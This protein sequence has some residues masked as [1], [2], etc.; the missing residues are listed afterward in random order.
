MAVGYLTK[1]SPRFMGSQQG[2]RRR[3]AALQYSQGAR[4]SPDLDPLHHA[5]N[6]SAAIQRFFSS[7]LSSA[8]AQVYRQ[9]RRR[10][11]NQTPQRRTT[12]RTRSEPAGR[13]ARKTLNDAQAF[14]RRTVPLAYQEPRLFPHGREAPPAEMAN[15]ST[16][17]DYGLYEHQAPVLNERLMGKSLAGASRPIHGSQH[18]ALPRKTRDRCVVPFNIRL[19]AQLSLECGT[20]CGGGRIS[21]CVRQS[22]GFRIS[23]LTESSGINYDRL[24]K[25]TCAVALIL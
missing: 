24:T 8:L 17:S 9:Q 14:Q 11:I 20:E 23:M 22:T 13:T 25:L 2:R 12:G 21:F 3:R 1:A 10:V 6:Y 15:R 16:A 5:V 7:L 4:S 19:D 18:S